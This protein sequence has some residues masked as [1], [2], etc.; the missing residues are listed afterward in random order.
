MNLFLNRDEVFVAGGQP[1]HTYVERSG[2]AV[3]RSLAR[4]IATPNQIVSLAG[5]TKTGK[6]VLCKNILEQRQY[7]WVD[8]GQ[9]KSIDAFWT[10]V[11]GELSLPDTTEITKASETALEV[12]GELPWVVTAKGSKLL[13]SSLVERRNASTPAAAIAQM[14]K[15]KAILVIDDFHYIPEASRM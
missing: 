11:C 13:S 15:A 8:G 3:E 2:E 10:L 5:P 1:T 12:G 6:T 4:A 9:V 7:I 14:Q